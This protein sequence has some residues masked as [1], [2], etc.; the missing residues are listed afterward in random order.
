MPY[1]LFLII[2]YTGIVSKWDSAYSAHNLELFFT[3]LQI[4]RCNILLASVFWQVNWN[5]PIYNF[6]NLAV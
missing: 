1:I 5:L 4:Y 3:V 6:G 2:E